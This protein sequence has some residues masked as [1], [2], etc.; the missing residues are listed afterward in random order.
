VG[1]RHEVV[2]DSSKRYCPPSPLQSRGLATS[3]HPLAPFT[4]QVTGTPLPACD[5]LPLPPKGP[6]PIGLLKKSAGSASKKHAA[7]VPH[8][9]A[10]AAEK[11]AGEGTT[12]P[13]LLQ[14]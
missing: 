8:R 7:G 14:Q 12:S 5:A 9:V 1:E 10:H 2:E 3:L 6:T 13:L 11:R 4:L